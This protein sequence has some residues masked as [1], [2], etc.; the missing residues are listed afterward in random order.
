MLVKDEKILVGGGPNYLDTWSLKTGTLLSRQGARQSAVHV[1]GVLQNGDIL[2]GD[3]NGMLITWR[4]GAP[5]GRS[6]IHKGAITALAFSKDGFHY[7]TAGAD[8]QI[9]DW[10]LSAAKKKELPMNH[11]GPITSLAYSASATGS[12]PAPAIAPPKRGIC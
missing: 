4:E 3:A 5:A 9:Y 6:L 8:Q 1:V 11:T 7:A 2:S 10:P 12:P